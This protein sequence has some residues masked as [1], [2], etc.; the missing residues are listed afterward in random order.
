MWFLRLFDPYVVSTLPL[1]LQAFSDTIAAVRDASQS[2]AKAMMSQLSGPGVKQ[3]LK[4]LLEG[5][6][7]KQWRT[8]LGSIELLAAMSSCLPKQLTTCLPQV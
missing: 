2:A 3:I 4:P 8:K 7:D 6:K 5:I 1:L